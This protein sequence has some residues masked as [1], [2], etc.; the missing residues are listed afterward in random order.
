MTQFEFFMAFY[1]LLLGLALAELLLGFANILRHRQRP[2][3]GLLTPLLGLLVFL[4]LMA[5]FIDAWTRLQGIAIQIDSL[6]LPTGIGVLLFFV[7]VI[8]V[9]RD[10]EDW[11]DLDE[12]FMANRRWAFGLLIAA[13]VLVLGYEAPFVRVLIE[14]GRWLHFAYYIAINILAFG[15]LTGAMLLRPRPAVIACLVVQI[16]LFVYVFSGFSLVIFQTGP[17]S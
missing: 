2:E 6:A 11:R 1:G 10:P 7:S 17:S 3:L 4:Q 14:G 16:A 12:Y 8:V 9:P 15:S 5:V 13:N